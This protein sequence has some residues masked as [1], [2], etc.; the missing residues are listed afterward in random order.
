MSFLLTH[1]MYY[2]RSDLIQCSS[3]SGDNLIWNTKDEEM[4]CAIYRNGFTY[5]LANTETNESR[6][7]KI[8]HD[9]MPDWVNVEELNS[10]GRYFAFRI[11]YS[12]VSSD[13][14][15]KTKCQQINS[16]A[17]DMVNLSP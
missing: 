8:Y 4:W 17:W 10:D 13:L 15:I 2:L 5:I 12:D 16:P 6:Q 9:K 14:T 3:G 1:I 11:K 7:I